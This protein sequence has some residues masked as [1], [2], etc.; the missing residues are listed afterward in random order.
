MVNIVYLCDLKRARL[1]LIPS[2]CLTIAADVPYHNRKV[3]NYQM[4]PFS[5]CRWR[6][7]LII[8]RTN[9]DSSRHARPITRTRTLGASVSEPLRRRYCRW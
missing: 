5:K 6:L 3:Q 8:S 2:L 7:L 9:A 4:Q 1:V